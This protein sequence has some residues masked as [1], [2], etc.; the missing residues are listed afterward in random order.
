[1]CQD[2]CIAAI[3]T[4]LAKGGLGVIRIS[5][6]GSIEKASKIFKPFRHSNLSDLNGYEAAYG[7]VVDLKDC[8]VDD[9]VA[10]IFRAPHSYT[11]EDVVEFSC[12]GG[13]AILGLILK[14]CFQVGC[15]PAL[16]GEFTKRA[17]LNGKISLTQAE[18]VI[19]LINAESNLSLK[20]AVKLKDGFLFK[21]TQEMC[22]VLVEISAQIEA[23]LNYPDEDVDE[24]D[25]DVLVSKIGRVATELKELTRSCQVSDYVKNGVRTVLVGEPNVGKST[26]MNLIIG[27]DVSITT[28]YSGTTRDVIAKQFEI[29][30]INFTFM[31]T[32]GIRDAKT[33]IE[34]IGIERAKKELKNAH[35]ILYVVD[36]SKKGDINLLQKVQKL[37]NVLKVLVLNK[38]DIKNKGIDWEINNFDAV[39]ETTKFNVKTVQELKNN[40]IKLVKTKLVNLNVEV[41]VNERQ[42]IVIDKLIEQLKEIE[43]DLK[44]GVSLDAICVSLELA[45]EQVLELNGQKVS[46]EVLDE[47]FSKFC[48]GK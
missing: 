31:D 21:K 28:K 3:A 48:V 8:K 13:V 25:S 17:F 22:R 7:Y 37:E 18:A 4:P 39:V 34:Q 6:K 2:D 42:K 5:G 9:V 47:I 46:E 14:L 11:G 24:P 38:S 45:I 1:M 10:L 15:R 41:F 40:I 16:G 32:A 26:L 27:Q 19:D 43:S 44:K 30:G 36:C 29:E 23:Y 35:L 20:S 33:T 12:H